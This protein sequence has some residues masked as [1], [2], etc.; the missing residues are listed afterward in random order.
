MITI[1]M[2][3]PGSGKSTYLALMVRKTL[4]QGRNAWS[5]YHIKGCKK[6]VPSFDLGNSLIEH[7]DLFIDESGREHNARD[8]RN[9]TKQQY[10]FYTQHRHY[11]IDHIYLAV[12]FWDRVD[13]TIRE[14]VQEIVILER[15]MFKPFIRAHIVDVSIGINEQK[16]I[17]EMFEFRHFLAGG[18]RYYRKKPAWDMFDSWE[19]DLSLV[20]KEWEVWSEWEEKESLLKKIKGRSINVLGRTNYK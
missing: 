7:G 20:E 3:P 4:K 13:I 1:V 19:R 11:H 12:Q 9:F 8:Y 17:D 16:K 5:N 6:L 10:D 18:V 15:T 2:G 14:L